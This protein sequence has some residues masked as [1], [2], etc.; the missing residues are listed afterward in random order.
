MHYVLKNFLDSVSEE[1]KT[2]ISS[3]DLE[4]I[5][6]VILSCNIEHLMTINGF[7]SDK[8]VSHS[9]A[10]KGFDL[11]TAQ[12]NRVRKGT[13]EATGSTL[14]KLAIG[15]NLDPSEFMYLYD[16]AGF[17]PAGKPIGKYLSVEDELLIEAIN[18][19]YVSLMQPNEQAA[20]DITHLIKISLP[21]YRASLTGN[22]KHLSKELMEAMRQGS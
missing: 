21:S 13:S 5:P 11:S 4:K 19:A 2:K 3:A 18:N 1:I 6:S 8:A 7:T 12:I 20:L 22:Y 9:I 15:L 14:F 16:P 10:D 17:T